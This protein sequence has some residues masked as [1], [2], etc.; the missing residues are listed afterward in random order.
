VIVSILVAVDEGGGIGY[1]NRVPWHI[2]SDLVRF[3]SLTMG[4]HILMGRKTFESIGKPLPGR[5]TVVITRRNYS[6]PEDCLV[7]GSLA[8]GLALA[9]S[10]GETESFVVGGGEIFALALPYADRIYLTRVHAVVKSD[11]FFPFIDEAEWRVTSQEYLPASV[12]DDYATTFAIYERPAST[13]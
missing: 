12:K 8:Q 11:V 13:D 10:Q 4:H 9:E 2:S 7:V 1:R 3:K 6:C 5:I